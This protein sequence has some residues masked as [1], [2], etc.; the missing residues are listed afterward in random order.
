MIYWNLHLLTCTDNYTDK[1]LI[2]FCISH[3]Y[4]GITN[5]FKNRNDEIHYDTE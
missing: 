2:E 4:S 5:T 1:F 3:A